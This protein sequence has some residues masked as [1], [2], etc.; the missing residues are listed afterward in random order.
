MDHRQ[1]P[2]IEVTDDLTCTNCGAPECYDDP[3][4]PTGK[5]FNIRAFKVADKHGYWW[6]HCLVCETWF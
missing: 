2:K 6:S 4:S 3:T 5:R 1:P